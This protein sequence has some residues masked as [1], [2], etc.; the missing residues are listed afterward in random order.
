[1]NLTVDAV[2][3]AAIRYPAVAVTLG[4]ALSNDLINTNPFTRLIVGFVVTFYRQHRSI[5]QTGDFEIWMSGLPAPQAAGVREALQRLWAIDLRSYTPE[6]LANETIGVLRNVA[7]QNAVAR[8]NQAGKHVTPDALRQITDQLKAIEPVSLLGLADVRDVQRWVLPEPTQRMIPTGIDGLD[9]MIGGWQKELVF[10]LADSGIGKTIFLINIGQYAM[11]M[12][13]RVLHIT[14]ELSDRRTI[15]RIYRRATESDLGTLRDR[16]ELVVEGMRQF[17]RYNRGTYHVL[18]RP[19]YSMTTEDLRATVGQ[20]VEQYGSV[21]M[22]VLDMLDLMKPS[23]DQARLSVY[24]RLGQMTHETRN[25]TFEFDC[26]LISATQ[27][28][29]RASGATR[30]TQADMGDSYNKVRGAGIIIGLVQTEEELRQ[31]Q[32]R[33]CLV[34]VRDTGGTGREVPLYINR[35][36]M[37][38]SDLDHP[39][40]RAVMARLGHAPSPVLVQERIA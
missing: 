27:A 15:Q 22:I 34:K 13:H 23:P 17:L 9:R 5:P 30:I 37:L 33:A 4:P 24:D 3:A 39:N 14:Y 12:G 32:G 10:V 6:Y 29:R 25:L 2:I 38:I 31:H 1:V 26:D 11:L 36:L 20:Y 8:L 21:D 40:T 7:A 28:I 16:P 19:A 18:Y 35:D